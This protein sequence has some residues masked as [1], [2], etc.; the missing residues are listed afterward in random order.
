M[1]LIFSNLML[2]FLTALIVAL[3]AATAQAASVVEFFKNAPQHIFPLLPQAARLDM[4]DYFAFGSTNP[5]RNSFGGNA[6][7]TSLSDLVLGADIDTGVAVQIA[8]LTSQKTDTVIA[9]VTTVDT[10][11]P[12][13]SIEFFDKT[14]KPLKRPPFKMPDYS[15]WLTEDGRKDRSTVQM[16]LPFMPV[17]AA[18]DPQA[19]MLVLTNQ[20]SS[21]LEPTDFQKV[22]PLIVQ[23]VTYDISESKFKKRN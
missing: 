4:A 1:R 9:V 6:R 10:P 12:V 18:F 21:Y 22:M 15:A 5:T 16:Q 7:I 14:W 11:M 17:S 13:S 2:R 19:S 3:C 8:L 23:S 20:A